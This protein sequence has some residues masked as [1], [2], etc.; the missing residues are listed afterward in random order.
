MKFNLTTILV[1]GIVALLTLQIDSCFDGKK[2]NTDGYKAEIKALEEDKKEL[3]IE[4][5]E[6]KQ[7]KETLW[8]DLRKKDSL[9]EQKKRPIEYHIKN[10]PVIVNAT[11]VNDVLDA[12]EKRFG[13]D[14]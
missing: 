4:V 2:V 10:I 11:A 14:Q 9:Y 1:A 8:V 3:K 13:Q 6:L 12:A 7:D 5:S